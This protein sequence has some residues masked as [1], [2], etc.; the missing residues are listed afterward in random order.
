M[1][2]TLFI[3]NILLLIL[4]SI[5]L[6]LSFTN[7][8]QTKKQ[9]YLYMSIMFLFFIFDNLVIY[10]TEFIDSFAVAYNNIFLSV[11]TYKTIIIIVLLVCYV[12]IN[13]SILK[14]ETS[15]KWYF[16][17]GALWFIEMFIAMM[18][19]GA[20]KVWLFYLP[21]QIFTFMLSMYGLNVIKNNPEKYT[22]KNYD[23]YR[24]VL[25][26]T[27]VFSILIF[28]E[29]TF[30]IFNVDIYSDIMIKINNRS[31]TEDIMSIG[32]CV[33]AIKYF[34][35][36]LYE[37]KENSVEPF[38]LEN[39]DIKTVDDTNDVTNNT[40]NN[41][42]SDFYLFCTQFYLTTREQDV[43]KLLIKDMDNKQISEELSI[44]IGTVKTHVHNI[45]L[46]TNSSSRKQLMDTYND[47][48]ENR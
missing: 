39:T 7:F 46:K 26:W 13:N 38:T 42:I 21:S 36:L 11:P 48:V 19:N 10:M 35:E 30:V 9:S 43:F 33:F 6:T 22:G 32:Y 31:V 14:I 27:L 47:F 8:L 2:E 3:Y 41:E 34:I 23:D 37:N 29:D 16:V 20:M 18:P 44:S 15:K 25:I 1:E 45:F 40:I 12:M 24:K 5:A 17:I 4:Y 28:I